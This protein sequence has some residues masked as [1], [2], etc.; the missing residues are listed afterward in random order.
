[1]F[2]LHLTD[3]LGTVDFEA[4]VEKGGPSGQAG[5]V[6][7]ALSVALRSLVHSDLV[8]KMRLGRTIEDRY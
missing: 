6:R 5:A 8:E 7:L 2:P 1:M 3:K 4:T